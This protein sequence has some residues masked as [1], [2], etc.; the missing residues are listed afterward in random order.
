MKTIYFA[1][2]AS[3]NMIGGSYGCGVNFIRA[4]YRKAGD[5]LWRRVEEDDAA[6]DKRRLNW[7]T[8]WN[9]T[10]RH[11]IWSRDESGVSFCDRCSLPP[12]PVETELDWDTLEPMPEIETSQFP[13]GFW[14]ARIKNNGP[15]LYSTGME[16]T[17]ATRE[18]AIRNLR[19]IQAAIKS[20]S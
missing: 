1:K 4:N 13:Q 14:N 5:T 7:I 8:E 6:A 9:R 19:E 3:G 16:T 17:G 11:E 2:N 15:I 18:S 20:K 10:G 12:T